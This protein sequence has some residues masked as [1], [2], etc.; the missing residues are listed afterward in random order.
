L[1]QKF[2]NYLPSFDID[3]TI[4]E[5]FIVVKIQIEIFWVV[6]AHSVAV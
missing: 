2:S 6:T 5:I 1:A 3:L 4:F